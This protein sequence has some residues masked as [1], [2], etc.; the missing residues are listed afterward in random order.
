MRKQRVPHRVLIDQLRVGARTC[1]ASIGAAALG[2][3]IALVAMTALFLLLG[4]LGVSSA[5]N[6]V[7]SAGQ[8]A[9]VGLYAVQLVGLSFF[10][11][12]AEL[13]FAAIPGLFLVGLSITLGTAVVV[14]ATRGS[15]K[16][17]MTVALAA[18]IPY[19]LLLGSAALLVP[20]HFTAPGLAVGISVSPSPAEAFL[21]P[22]SWGLLFASLGGLIGVLGRGWRREASRLL[23]GWAVPFA[24]LLRVMAVGLAATAIVALVGGLAVSGWDLGSVIDGGFSHTIKVA[25]AALI[26]LPTAAAAVFVSGFGVSFDWQVDALS[27]GQGSISALGGTLP[28]SSADPSQAHGAPGVLALAPF[29]AIAAVFA[30]GWLSARR[31]GADVRRG[32][33]NA[34]RAAALVTLAVWLFALIARVDTQIGGLLGF[35][36]VPDVGALLWRVPLVALVGCFG[37]SLAYVFTQGASARRHLVATLRGAVRSFSWGRAPGGPGQ[38]RWISHG[39]TWRAALGVGF[40][41]VPVLLVGLGATGPASLAAPEEV[42][43]ASISQTAEQRLER[44]STDDES[45]AVTVNPETKVVG[46]ASVHTPLRALDIA[47]GKS[48]AAKAEDVLER[49]G[50]LFG[51]DDATAELGNPQSSTDK[52]GVTHVSFTQV[53][54]GLPVFAGGIGVHLSNKGE[55]LDFVSGSLI[56]DV[57][58]AEKKAK[59][60]R[61]DATEIA[62]GALSSGSLEQPPSLQVF[63]GREPYVSGPNARLAWFVWLASE[64]T[65]ASEEYVVDAVTGEILDTIPKADY[66]KVREVYD[67][68]GGP[69]LPGELAREEGEETP[70]GDADVDS[71]YDHTGTVYDFYQGYGERDSWDGAGAPIISTVHFD[72]ASGAPFENAYWNG[73][74]MVFGDEYADALDIVGHELTHAVVEHDTELVA[75]AQSGALNESFS[76]IMGATIEM[77]KEEEE[78]WEIGEDLPGGAIRSLSKPSKYSEPVGEE[79]AS[80][81]FPETLTKWVETCLDNFGIH[82]NSTITSH[83]FYLAATELSESESMTPREVAEVFYYGWTEYL[84]APSPTLEDAR[85]ATLEA[86][87]AMWGKE[88]EVEKEVKA[89][90]NAVGLN[91]VAQPELPDADECNG[92]PGCS[93]ARALQTR[94]SASGEDAAEMLATLYK[95]R[96]ELA[97]TTAAGD[98]FM[99]L[100]E[101]NMVRINELVTL[102]PVVGEMAVSGLEEITPALDALV[103]GNGEEFELT[104]EQMERIEAALNRLAKDDRLY[105]GE[106]A[107]VLADLI[108]EEL[109]WMGLASYGGMDYQSG[110]ERLNGEVETQM[111]MEEEGVIMDPNCTGQPYPNNFH[112]NSFYA[113]TPGHTLPGQVSPFTAGGVICGAEVEAQFGK[114]GCVREGSLNTEVSVKLPPG[115]KVNSSKNLPAGSWVGELYGYGIGCAGDKTRLIYGQ[116]GLLS[117]TSWTEEQCPASVLACYEG[118]STYKEGGNSVIGKGYAWIKEEGGALT[119]TTRPINVETLNGYKIKMSFG[120]FEASLCGRAGKAETESCGGPTAT[121]IHQNGEAAEP[122]CPSSAGRFE[123][124]AKNYAG[125]S[126]IPV[127][128]CVRWDKGAFMQA[129]DA[130]NSLNA[131]SCVPSST[132]CIASDDKGNARYSTAASTSAAATWNSWSGPGES[133]SHD[134]AC[135]ASTLCVLSTGAV[136]G[137]GGNVYRA[138]SLGG[139]FLSSFKPTNGVGAISC[140][141]TSFC[142]SAQEGGGFI[143]WST[144]PSGTSWTAVAIGTGAMRDVSC[145]SSSFCAV[146]DAAGNVRVATSEAKIKEAGGWKATSVNGG[147]ALTSVACASTT[148][149]IAIDGNDEVLN[150]TISGTGSATVSG[151][152]VAE[153]E[154]LNDV[155]CTGTT[156]AAVGAEGGIFASSNSG[157]TWTR[158]F[159]AAEPLMAVSCAS[160]SLCAAVTNVGDVVTFDP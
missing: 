41:S 64:T 52:F 147:V 140:P 85:A 46:T 152:T 135:P 102:D 5:P 103:E 122:G 143:R 23:G 31:S 70:T 160:S 77:E 62:K 117:L 19:A 14:R 7:V 90:F 58:V 81:S 29:I 129:I 116:A 66:A 111:L 96:G 95:A 100:Y 79:G 60:S 121:W 126:T 3:G 75:S 22:L 65:N 130:P 72:Q 125:E 112:I 40:A 149:C 101:S 138:S 153:G 59:L 97:L 73:E 115:D 136:S 86:A 91:G 127:T 54:N 28:S 150:L 142:V 88:S 15:T 94:Q 25:G 38:T 92:G 61:Q 74:Q 128:T 156:C 45:V 114:S 80:V 51:L 12:T 48:R 24:S 120:Q 159:N 113:D 56:P 57:F 83:A 131:V 123:M 155:T 63:A 44:A 4:A 78:D 37:G 132:T 32:L 2:V 6:S 144:K 87:K 110:F 84:T 17:R 35:H 105:G 53:A 137:G 11:G 82:I 27:H 1:G 76:D 158:R 18:A 43:L 146:V 93:F 13:R 124:K 134:I 36:L 47:P 157:S 34:L 67:W 20:L 55:L 10:N 30:V 9:V 16:R 139:T 106:G 69:E 119:L 145:L 104:S 98:H 151:Q 109:E 26:A 68:E 108:E 107:G 33:A 39:L 89:A 154:E 8:D 133:P 71:A 148:A 21:L 141:S 42:S 99:P 49:Y 50:E 118:R